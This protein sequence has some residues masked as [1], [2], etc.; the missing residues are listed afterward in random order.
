VQTVVG[1]FVSILL[2]IVVTWIAIFGGIGALLS[3]SRGGS[4]PAGLAWGMGLGPIGWLAILWTTRPADIPAEL[5]L[6][7]IPSPPSGPAAQTLTPDRPGA[8]DRW[9]PWNER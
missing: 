9:D 3:R 2:L 5:D 7:L 1:V 4:T 6:P 8:P